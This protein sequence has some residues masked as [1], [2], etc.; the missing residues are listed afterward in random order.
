MKII[1]N[2]INFHGGMGLCPLKKRAD[3]DIFKRFHFR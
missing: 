3:G 1:D 2:S